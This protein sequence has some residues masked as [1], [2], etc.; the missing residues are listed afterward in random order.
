[1]MST[2]LWNKEAEASLV[3][4]YH[5]AG[6][7]ALARP[8]S[9]IGR[10][11][12]S[13]R[14]LRFGCR[15]K[16]RIY[17]TDRADEF[18]VTNSGFFINSSLA[19]VHRFRRRFISVCNVLKGIKTSGVTNARTSALWYRLAAVTKM[20]PIGPI[21]SFEPGTHWIPRS[22]WVLQVGHGRLIFTQ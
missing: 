1:M 11:D 7:P 18:D 3:R 6:C 22:P 5:T 9:F 20:G 13:L 10:G 21:T 8:S 16:D 12:L 15:C 17:R 4:A 14:T 19:P 2:P